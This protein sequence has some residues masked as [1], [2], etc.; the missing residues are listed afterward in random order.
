MVEE[1]STPS[2]H[3]LIPLPS[4]SSLPPPPKGSDALHQ[5]MRQ[6]AMVVHLQEEVKQLS[7]RLVKEEQLAACVGKVEALLAT[8]APT[9]E[10]NR[11]A[12][13]SLVRS[14]LSSTREDVGKTS[15]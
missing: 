4:H 3:S 7:Q 5:R 1:H 15:R 10:M 6:E 2:H 8:C 12:L 14:R 11:S 13:D 9:A